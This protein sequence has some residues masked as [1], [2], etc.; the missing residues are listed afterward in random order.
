MKAQ[1]VSI[2]KEAKDTKSFIFKP[3][4]RLEFLP[5]QYFY[6]TLP[7]LSQDDPRGPTRHFT[8]SSSPTEIDKTVMFTTRIRS[9]SGFK[10][11]LN[12]LPIGSVVNIEGPNGT[13]ILDRKEKTTNQVFLAGGIGVTPYRSFIKYAID[14][15]LDFSYHLICSNSTPDDMVFYSEL[16][17]LAKDY[18]TNLQV[19]F[20]ITQPTESKSKWNGLVGRIDSLLLNK[21]IDDLQNKTFWLTGPPNM[22]SAT[23]D[24]LHTLH[25]KNTNIR[26]EKFTGY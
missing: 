2:V 3:E 5:G 23:E 14:N 18:P 11:T 1:L 17:N 8:I 12:S 10:Q 20:I 7:K 24:I 4:R 16:V 21:L 25:V 26:S 6:F 15:S 19:D 22:V 13:F 9:Q